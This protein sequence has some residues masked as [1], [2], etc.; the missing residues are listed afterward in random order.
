MDVEYHT[1]DRAIYDRVL[2]R[3]GVLALTSDDDYL[4]NYFVKNPHENT[5]S[6]HNTLLAGDQFSSKSTVK[7]QAL[8]EGLLLGAQNV[9]DCIHK[10]YA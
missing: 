1:P 8:G 7:L 10:L 6:R 3:H 9:G 4:Y 2:K 5:I